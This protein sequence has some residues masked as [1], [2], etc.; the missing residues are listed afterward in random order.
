MS[1]ATKLS[2]SFAD[3][4]GSPHQQIALKQSDI[5]GLKNRLMITSDPDHAHYGQHLTADQVDSFVRPAETTVEAV[6][7]WFAE[8]GLGEQHVQFSAAQDWAVSTI[9]LLFFTIHCFYSLSACLLKWP[10]TCSTPNTVTTLRITRT[11]FSVSTLTRCLCTY[12]SSEYSSVEQ[13]ICANLMS[14]ID[15]I[16]PTTYFSTLK[17]LDTPK[18]FTP[19]DFSELADGAALQGISLFANNN[20]G[21]KRPTFPS[22]DFYCNQTISVQCLRDL[23]GTS[24]YTANPDNGNRLGITAYLEEVANRKDLQ[25]FLSAQRPEAEGTTFTEYLVN[26]GLNPQFNDAANSSGTMYVSSS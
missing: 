13:L 8:H 1:E 22:D 19:A 4:C 11:L 2:E 16:Q 18:P 23:Y 14:S 12:M 20:G 17:P 9:G 21:G 5:N 26:G 6:K 25:T 15:T 24:E 10:I 3:H 7:A